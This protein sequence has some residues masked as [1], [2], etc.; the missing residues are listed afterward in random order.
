[1]PNVSV[2]PS[3]SFLTLQRSSGTTRFHAIWLRDNSPD[4]ETRSPSNG[5]RLIALRDVAADTRI[6]SARIDESGAVEVT[7]TPEEKTVAFDCGWLERHNYD[8]QDTDTRGWLP[9]EIR[10]WDGS[11]FAAAP[12]ADFSDLQ[13]GGDVL[14]GWLSDVVTYGFAKVSGA[15][16]EE[17]ALFQL[18]DLFG[19]VRET[20]YGRHFEV[21]T[22]SLIHI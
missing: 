11:S 15:P 2:D 5:Q 21:R 4:P 10:T 14:L 6:A 7:F 9:A 18:V 22:L 3:G 12:C 8:R 13:D 17:G 20:N 16:V 19:Y 1:M